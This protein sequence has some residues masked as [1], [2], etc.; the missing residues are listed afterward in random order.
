MRIETWARR[1]L[2]SAYVA[3]AGIGIRG[4]QYLSRIPRTHDS[5]LPVAPGFLFPF[6]SP[7]SPERI[8]NHP[9]ESHRSG[10]P[11]TPPRGV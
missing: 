1:S 11:R 5:S 6:P 7:A 8:T 2:Q 3:A 4:T 10:T 9:S